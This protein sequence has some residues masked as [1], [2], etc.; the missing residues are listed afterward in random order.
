MPI[1]DAQL[2]LSD[3]Q[4][5]SA[6]AAASVVGESVVYI[7]QVKDHRVDIPGDWLQCLPHA[8]QLFGFM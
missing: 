8:F 7:P 4:D 2:M 1:M 6:A 5:I 3:A